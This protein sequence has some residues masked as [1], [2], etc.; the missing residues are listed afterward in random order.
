[1]VSLRTP[2]AGRL[3]ALAAWLLGAASASTALAQETP[4][5]VDAAVAIL[6]RQLERE[7]DRR[8]R[9]KQ[10][11]VLGRIGTP[12]AQDALVER[13][14]VDSCDEVRYTAMDGLEAR[15]PR[16]TATLVAAL[17]SEDN[18]VVNRAA[19]G[20]KFLKDPA[21][22]EPLINALVTTHKY[23]IVQPGGFRL[24]GLPPGPPAGEG[25][26]MSQIHSNQRCSTRWLR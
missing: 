16:V 21:A 4:P 24:L 1:M 25:V 17:K 26:L 3:L 19:E 22:V 2:R 14:L 11:M 10:V 9:A 20:L 7:P 18:H 8:A 5:S 6:V 13:I 15:P 12:A 23:R